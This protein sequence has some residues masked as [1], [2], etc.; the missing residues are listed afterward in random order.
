MVADF[1]YERA[2]LTVMRSEVLDRLFYWVKYRRGYCRR[3]DFVDYLSAGTS[4]MKQECNLPGKKK[5]KIQRGDQTDYPCIHL[6]I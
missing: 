2:I 6:V 3:T 1:C 4:N 5:K